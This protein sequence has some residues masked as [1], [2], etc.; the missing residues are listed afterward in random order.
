MLLTLKEEGVRYLPDLVMVGFY[1]GGMDAMWRSSE[2]TIS[3]GSVC[4]GEELLLTNVP[5]PRTPPPDRIGE[6]ADLPAGEPQVG[7]VGRAPG[8]QG[9]AKP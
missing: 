2:I 4:K 7:V 6:A 3:R 1:L 5:V 8:S 9:A